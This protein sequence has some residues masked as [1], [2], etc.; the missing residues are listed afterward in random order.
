MENRFLKDNKKHHVMDDAEFEEFFDYPSFDD[1]LKDFFDEV[2]E[3]GDD[4]DYEEE[5][6]E[7]DPFGEDYQSYNLD[8]YDLNLDDV[9]SDYYESFGK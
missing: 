9:E 8:D 3:S 1:E 5:L 2:E 6:Q 4:S 7:M